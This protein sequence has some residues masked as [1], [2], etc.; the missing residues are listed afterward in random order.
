MLLDV[1][2]VWSGELTAQQFMQQ[3]QAQ[4]DEEKAAG[5]LPPIPT[6]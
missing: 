3:L 2:K 4:F 6:R 5:E 1:E